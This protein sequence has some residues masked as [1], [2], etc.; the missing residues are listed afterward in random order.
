MEEGPDVVFLPKDM[1]INGF[2]LY[3]FSSRAW[4][5]T[6]FDRSGG[7]RLDGTLMLMG[8]G[9]RQGHELENAALVDLAPTVLAAMGVAVPDDMDG[10]VLVEAFDESYF[11]ERP[12]RYATAHSTGSRGTR[13]L[14]SDEQEMIKERL[15]GLGYIA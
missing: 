6:S 8:P 14:S 12:I 2:G 10:R 1:S 9:I 11:A 13:D 7:H 15:R 4:I 3:Q 5:D